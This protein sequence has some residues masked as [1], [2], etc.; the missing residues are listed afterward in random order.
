VLVPISSKFIEKAERDKMEGTSQ[1]VVN[2][3]PRL[4]EMTKKWLPARIKTLVWGG[5]NP[6]GGEGFGYRTGTCTKQGQIT[7]QQKFWKKK[8]N[9][10]E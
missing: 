8:K 10:G 3:E 4:G 2:R 7:R 5:K 1:G 6:L 9:R